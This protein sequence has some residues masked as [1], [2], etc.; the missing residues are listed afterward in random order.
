MIVTWYLYVP[1][2]LGFVTHCK[3][4]VC[5]LLLNKFADVNCFVKQNNNR[6]AN[7]FNNFK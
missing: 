2:L 7:K 1:I 3:C 4:L 5:G 6:L